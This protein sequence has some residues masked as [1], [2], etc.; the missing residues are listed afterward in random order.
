[1][2][3]SITRTEHAE[4]L[5]IPIHGAIRE[6]VPPRQRTFRN[7][8]RWT[9]GAIVSFAILITLGLSALNVVLR[10]RYP[11][12]FTELKISPLGF[13]YRQAVEPPKKVD[14]GQ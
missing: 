12:Q 9:V 1:M 2:D 7:L 13:A 8:K 11:E 10:T 6:I 4:L 5:G 14:N 3:H